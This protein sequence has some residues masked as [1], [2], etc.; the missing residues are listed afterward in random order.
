VPHYQNVKLLLYDSKGKELF[1]EDLVTK[2]SDYMRKLDFSF[3]KAG[4]YLCRLQV[5][6]QVANTKVVLM[7]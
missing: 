4:V 2:T 5:V 6:T 1:R 3:N 7:K